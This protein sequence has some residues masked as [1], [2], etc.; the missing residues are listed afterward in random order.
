MSEC[1]GGKE[2]FKI[3]FGL[4]RARISFGPLGVINQ[5]SLSKH[6]EEFIINEQLSVTAKSPVD[7]QRKYQ[8]GLNTISWVWDPETPVLESLRLKIF[9]F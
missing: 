8:G 2:V 4:S 1:G 6:I 9:C 5:G 7:S 3:F